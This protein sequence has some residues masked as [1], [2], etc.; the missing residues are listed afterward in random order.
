LLDRLVTE[1]RMNSDPWVH[2]NAVYA[3]G[4]QKDLKTRSKW[5]NTY[6]DALNYSMSAPPKGRRCGYMSW[7]ADL[8]DDFLKSM[9]EFNIETAKHDFGRTRKRPSLPHQIRTQSK[10]PQNKENNSY[11]AK[12][13]E[14]RA[15]LVA[16]LEK[17]ND[18]PE[19]EMLAVS[20]PQSAAWAHDTARS[21]HRT[22]NR[23]KLKRPS[24]VASSRVPWATMLDADQ[25]GSSKDRGKFADRFKTAM[26][27]AKDLFARRTA[28]MNIKK[29]V[30]RKIA[31]GDVP[32]TLGKWDREP[33][34]Y[35]AEP[36]AHTR[37]SGKD[38][39]PIEPVPDCPNL[40]FA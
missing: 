23:T 5:N 21:E 33:R 6:G 37:I 31:P 38:A 15:A 27:P 11:E 40:F 8:P 7:M 24:T 18:T 16:Q 14:T 17:I 3:A 30:P 12:L 22:Q 9:Q 13:R 19:E 35:S 29:K 2:P 25:A 36:F 1:K 10:Q 26:Q 32:V 20:R 4:I 39:E 28:K 34:R